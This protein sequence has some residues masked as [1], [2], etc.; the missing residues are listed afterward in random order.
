MVDY[1]THEMGDVLMSML[2]IIDYDGGRVE[3]QIRMKSKSYENYYYFDLGFDFD[4]KTLTYFSFGL[5]VMGTYSAQRMDTDGKFYFSYE[6]GQADS[7]MI[8]PSA[9]FKAALDQ[10]ESDF[11]VAIN[12]GLTLTGN[13]QSEY[14][15]YTT[16]SQ[17]IFYESIESR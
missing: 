6:G 9:E 16:V 10:L 8:P 13:F 15:T 3:C 4:T 5:H 17:K 7:E 11:G 2:P 14:D 1:S 12:N